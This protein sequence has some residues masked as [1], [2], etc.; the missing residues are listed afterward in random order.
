[1]GQGPEL[2]IE[3]G[4]QLVRA[5][6]PRP[7]QVQRELGKRLDSDIFCAAHDELPPSVSSARQAGCS[8]APF[9]MWISRRWNAISILA[10]MRAACTYTARWLNTESPASNRSFHTRRPESHVL[11]GNP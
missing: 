8:R 9:R 1:M 11:Y 6:V 5:A 10:A 2:G 7:A 3:L 4:P